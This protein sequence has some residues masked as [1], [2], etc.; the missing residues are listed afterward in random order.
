MAKRVDASTKLIAKASN[1]YDAVAYIQ[2]YFSN[3]SEEAYMIDNWYV[4]DQLQSG[5][6]EALIEAKIQLEGEDDFLLIISEL[7][8]L[9][10]LKVI[11]M[12]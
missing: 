9:G 2:K 12:G 7:P 1:L 10:G 8:M 11:V 5:A 3:H 6:K 4:I